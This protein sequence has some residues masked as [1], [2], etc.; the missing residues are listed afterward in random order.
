MLGWLWL[1]VIEFF[2]QVELQIFKYKIIHKWMVSAISRGL[3]SQRNEHLGT[4]LPAYLAVASTER[5]VNSSGIVRWWLS[6]PS[7]K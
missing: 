2:N 7:N 5:K 4:R 6:L 1:D 3:W